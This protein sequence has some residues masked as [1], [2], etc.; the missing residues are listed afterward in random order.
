MYFEDQLYKPH[1]AWCIGCH[2][3]FNFYCADQKTSLILPS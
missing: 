3:V 1:T 2:W